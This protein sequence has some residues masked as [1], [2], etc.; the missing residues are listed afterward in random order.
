MRLLIITLF[1]SASLHSFS[2]DVKVVNYTQLEEQWTNNSDTLYIINYWATW[3]KPC[4]EEL[5][6]FI[7]LEQDSQNKKIKILLVSLDFASHADS[8]VA[9]FIKKMNITTKVVILADDANVWINK[10]DKNW[11]GAIPA[12]QFIKKGE[13]KFFA[14]QLSYERLKEIMNSYE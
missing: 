10:V 5:P 6:D 2:Q 11:S 7:K 1:L 9:P 8:R 4:V 12:T 13:R 3:C 14:E